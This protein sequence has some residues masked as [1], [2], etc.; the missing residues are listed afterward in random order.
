MNAEAFSSVP[1]LRP[2]ALID[3]VETTTPEESRAFVTRVTQLTEE[4]GGRRVLANEVI[5]PMIV[6]DERASRFDHATRLL[7][8]TQYRTKQAGQVALAKRRERG[9]ELF[10]ESIRTYVARP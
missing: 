5:V 8:I 3:L 10:T 7:V 9:P 2:V 4:I 1:P 6:S